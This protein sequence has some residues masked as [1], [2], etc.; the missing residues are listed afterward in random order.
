MPRTKP[1]VTCGVGRTKQYF[2]DECDVNNIMRHAL[3][4]GQI[5]VKPRGTFRDVTGLQMSFHEAQ[6]F[7][8]NASAK[9]WQLSPEI[10]MRFNNDVGALLAFVEDPANAEESVKLGLLPAQQTPSEPVP[11]P[12]EK[13]TPAA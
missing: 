12:A 10:R 8:V 6:N 3:E 5:H 2:R 13:E 9:F 4:T 7:I 1:T 11:P